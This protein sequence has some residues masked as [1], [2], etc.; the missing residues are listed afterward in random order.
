MKKKWIHK[1]LDKGLEG[2][3]DS[4]RDSFQSIR[5]EVEWNIH[6]EVKFYDTL[7]KAQNMN[8]HFGTDEFI[9]SLV[10]TLIKTPLLG[11]RQGERQGEVVVAVK[12]WRPQGQGEGANQRYLINPESVLSRGTKDGSGKESK[13]LRAQR[14]WE[15]GLIPGKLYRTTQ[16]VSLISEDRSKYQVRTSPSI[17][18]GDYV[19]L[20]AVEEGESPCPDTGNF[21]QKYRPIQGDTYAITVLRKLDFWTDHYYLNAF[22]R[23]GIFGSKNFEE[24]YIPLLKQKW[25]WIK[26]EQ[27]FDWSFTHDEL[28]EIVSND[29]NH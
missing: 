25:L 22:M 15:K 23:D 2:L 12:A 20:I 10:K 1:L 18:K 14:D 5:D 4:L 6:K 27:V 13:Y 3:F 11:E 19:L 8:T 17:A 16:M 7:I 26:N 21:T 28:E 24:N 9:H 29:D